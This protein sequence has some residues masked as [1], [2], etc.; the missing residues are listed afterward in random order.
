[1]PILEIRFYQAML[2]LQLVAAV[3][4]VWKHLACECVVV[5]CCVT[6]GAVGETL[7][8]HYNDKLRELR[9]HTIDE[10]GAVQQDQSNKVWNTAC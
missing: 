3:I 4:H 8:E 1:M 10:Q 6:A 7:T 9:E 5:E 2:Q